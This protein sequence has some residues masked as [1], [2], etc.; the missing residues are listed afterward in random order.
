M[1]TVRPPAPPGRPARPSRA[2]EVHL[3]AVS[4]AWERLCG[5]LPSGL[6]DLMQTMSPQLSGDPKPQ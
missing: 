3:C 5:R 4:P 2:C 1:G 6:R